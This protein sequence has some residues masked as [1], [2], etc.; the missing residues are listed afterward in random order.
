LDSLGSPILK[1]LLTSSVACLAD[2]G[3]TSVLGS[4]ASQKLGFFF[5]AE[6]GLDSGPFVVSERRVEVARDSALFLTDRESLAAD[7]R[8]R[9]SSSGNMGFGGTCS[10]AISSAGDDTPK[11]LATAS[12]ELR[13]LDFSATFMGAVGATGDSPLSKGADTSVAEVTFPLGSFRFESWMFESPAVVG[14]SRA[15]FPAASPL[16]RWGASDGVP[17]KLASEFQWSDIKL[18]ASFCFFR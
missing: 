18:Q 8:G 16:G 10:T 11:K 2:A 9:L 6:A 3:S 17:S 1:G 12:H 14:A 15:R 4:S 13:S 5:D 7:S